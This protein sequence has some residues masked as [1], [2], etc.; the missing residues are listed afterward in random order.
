MDCKEI[1]IKRGAL[2]EGHFCLSSGK[3]SDVYCQCARLTEYPDDANIIAKKIK[4]ELDKNNIKPDVVV[5]PAMGGILIAYELSRVLGVR[6]I[7]TERQDG[8][9]CFRRGFHIN[10]GEKVIISE[11]VVTTGKSSL[12]TKEAI[13]EMGG[14]VLGISC[15]V[16][17]TVEEPP[18]PVFSA[19]KI[20][21]NLYDEND[22]PLCKDNVEIEKPGSRFIKK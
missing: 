1:L 15:I 5:G 11:D 12:E 13:E 16:D 9:M 7:F 19:I 17:R 14:I 4:E 8:K 18:L 3:H 6:N 21:A 22:C 2:R 20:D 10:P